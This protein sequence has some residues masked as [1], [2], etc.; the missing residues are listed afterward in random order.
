MRALAQIYDNYTQVVAK[1]SSG[2]KSIE[3][4]KGKR[5]SVGAPNSGT[6]VIADRMLEAARH[7]SRRA[8]S[9]ARASASRSPCRR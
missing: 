8:A 5:V 4:L 1:A 3:D 6:E 2:I 9:S 7:R